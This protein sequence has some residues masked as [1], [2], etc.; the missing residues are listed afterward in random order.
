[1]SGY[2]DRPSRPAGGDVE[3]ER[4]R[5]R[6]DEQELAAGRTTAT[7]ALVLSSAI[8]VVAIGFALAL[9]IVVVAYLLA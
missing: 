3:D 1:M 5:E 8:T 7:P 9:A 4:P 6:T 2:P